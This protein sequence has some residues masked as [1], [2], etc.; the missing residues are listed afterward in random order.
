MEI[1]ILIIGEAKRIQTLS[2]FAR[3]VI[4]IF[5]QII[6]DSIN[7]IITRC[8][9]VLIV[10]RVHSNLFLEAIGQ[11]I[12]EAACKSMYG[13]CNTGRCSFR[14]TLGRCSFSYYYSSSS[15]SCSWGKQVGQYEFIYSN[16]GFKT[17]SADYAADSMDDDVS[18]NTLFVRKMVCVYDSNECK[19]VWRL[20]QWDLGRLG[21]S[22]YFKR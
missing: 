20:E 18:G 1:C 8:K 13:S 9:T 7:N 14:C 4:F 3:S 11:K 2:V 21:N 15:V 16:T 22:K 10:N 6:P 5:E 17:V 19:N 12:A